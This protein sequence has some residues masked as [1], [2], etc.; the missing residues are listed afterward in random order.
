[1]NYQKQMLET[2]VKAGELL[3]DQVP[4][5]QVIESNLLTAWLQQVT[6]ALKAVGLTDGLT[7]WEEARKIQVKVDSPAMLSIYA[8]SMR[9]IL[10]GLLYKIEKDGL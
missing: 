9:A 2:L 4:P 1:M 8:M 10:L 5:E 6:S 7:L 3:T